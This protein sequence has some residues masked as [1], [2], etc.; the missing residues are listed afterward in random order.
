MDTTSYVETLARFSSGDATVAE[1]EEAIARRLDQLRAT[2][3]MTDEQ[4]TLSI[5][6]LTIEE[7]R[8]GIRETFDIYV[9]AL[10]A[11]EELKIVPSPQ[12]ERETSDEVVPPEELLP[13]VTGIDS[14]EL[15]TAA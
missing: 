8:E 10:Q 14:A 4:R 9:T 11:L 7:A 3:T 2:P 12:A 6:E 15:V 1:L 5:I 13:R